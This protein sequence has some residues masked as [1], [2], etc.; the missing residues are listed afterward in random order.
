V[1]KAS[2]NTVSYAPFWGRPRSK[3][4]QSR[5]R[6]GCG[7]RTDGLRACS[8]T[9]PIPPARCTRSPHRAGA[10]ASRSQNPR[11]PRA[12]SCHESRGYR[13]DTARRGF[14]GTIARP[15]F[16]EHDL[17]YTL[18]ELGYFSGRKRHANSIVAAHHVLAAVVRAVNASGGDG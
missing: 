1:D 10:S 18:P 16:V 14:A 4:S 17:V 13:I 3:A 11:N 15:G 12:I 7:K 5:L 2:L 9:L 6:F 8:E